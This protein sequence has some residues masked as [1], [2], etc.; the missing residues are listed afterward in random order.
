MDQRKKATLSENQN[1]QKVSLFFPLLHPPTTGGN[2]G[3]HKLLIL[4]LLV[5][6]IALRS[7]LSPG[8]GAGSISGRGPRAQLIFHTLDGSFEL[9]HYAECQI[10]FSSFLVLGR[11]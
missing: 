11:G 5:V 8:V 3:L 10:H 7:R 6:I 9:F 2:V 1:G 4:T